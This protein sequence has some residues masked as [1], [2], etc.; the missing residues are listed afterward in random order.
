MHN[1]ILFDELKK[2]K[3]KEKNSNCDMGKSLDTF[4][5]VTFQDWIILLGL[6]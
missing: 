3:K 4:P 6:S 2:G 1:Y 5:G